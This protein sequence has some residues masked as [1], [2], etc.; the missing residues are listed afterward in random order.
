MK[1]PRKPYLSELEALD[2]MMA[3]DR[4][5][6]SGRTFYPGIRDLYLGGLFVCCPAVEEHLC[7]LLPHA[8]LTIA[9]TVLHERQRVGVDLFNLLALLQELGYE[10][11]SF[12]RLWSRRDL[13]GWRKQAKLLPV[14]PPRQPGLR[15]AME[16]DLVAYTY[17]GDYVQPRRVE[18]FEFYHCPPYEP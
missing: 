2:W 10:P 18:S 9:R 3:Y 12:C 1:H 7:Q 13:A 16:G 15:R 17:P 4:I 6:E 8:E 11:K 14:L 5:L